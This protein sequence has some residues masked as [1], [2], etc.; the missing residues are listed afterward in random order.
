MAEN[1]VCV[2]VVYIE[3][4][5]SDLHSFPSPQFALSLLNNLSVDTGLYLSFALSQ[6]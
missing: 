1:A 6:S 4:A 5:M 3:N 2:C